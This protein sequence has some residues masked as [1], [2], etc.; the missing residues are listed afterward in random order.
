MKSGLIIFSF[1]YMLLAA[2]AP[3]YNKY[4]VYEKEVVR[5]QISSEKAGCDKFD[6][7]VPDAYTIMHNV[8]V[9]FHFMRS[10]EGENHFSEAEG[11]AYVHELINMCNYRLANNAKMNL[12]KGNNTPNLKPQYQY[13]LTGNPGTGDDGIYFHADDSACWYSK[14]KKS[15]ANSLGDKTPFRYAVGSDTIFNIYFIEHHKDTVAKYP[16]YNVTSS[17]VSFG[18]NIKIFGAYGNWAQ[19]FYLDD[20]NTFSKGA[21][22]Y[23]GVVNH[24][25][26]HSLGLNHSWNSDDGCEDTP[27]HANC[28]G[29]TGIEPCIGPTSN[30]MMDYNNCQCALTPCQLAKIHYNF[31]KADARQYKVVVPDWCDYNPFNKV[32]IPR[33]STVVFPAGRE[34]NSDIE[35]SEYATLIVRCTVAL[36]AG[37]KIIIKPGGKLIIDGGIITNRCGEN[38][39]GIEIWESVKLKIKGEVVFANGGTMEQVKNFANVIK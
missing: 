10:T 31:W 28:W 19:V 33:D 27:K 7:Y 24:E 20:G 3:R 25:I 4:F 23:S 29:E 11:R 34:F 30:N 22:F 13:V 15:G 17:G 37:A 5:E 36:P 8:R 14:N 39:E 12:P 2:C 26:G 18:N 32:V 9:N 16:N 21:G 35:I 1:L 6:M 38:W